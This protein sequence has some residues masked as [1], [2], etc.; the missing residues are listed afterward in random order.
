[1]NNKSMDVGLSMG[2]HE[3]A[4]AE[5]ERDQ[6]EKKLTEQPAC[7]NQSTG[8]NWLLQYQNAPKR[9]P[10]RPKRETTNLHILN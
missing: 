1:M 2:D 6:E 7:N 3:E 8:S 4:E 10:T 5:G 9:A